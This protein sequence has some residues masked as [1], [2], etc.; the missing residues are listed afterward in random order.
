MTDGNMVNA[1]PMLWVGRRVP[2]EPGLFFITNVCVYQE[3]SVVETN[4]KEAITVS[5]S[6]VWDSK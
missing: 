2:N 6:I 3:Q 4:L 5:S 1:S